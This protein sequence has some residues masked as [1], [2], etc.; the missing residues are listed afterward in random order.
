MED[1]YVLYD[2]KCVYTEYK[3]SRMNTIHVNNLIIKK[4]RQILEKK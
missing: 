2:T 1:M 3:L 4:L